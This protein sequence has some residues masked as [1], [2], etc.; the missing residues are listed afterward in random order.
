MP[1]RPPIPIVLTSPTGEEN[2]CISYGA[3]LK[4]FHTN[5]LSCNYK[6]IGKYINSS[7]HWHGWFMKRS[8][9]IVTQNRQENNDQSVY[10]F[11]EDGI[12]QGKSVRV[13]LGLVKNVTLVFHI[14]KIENVLK[15]YLRI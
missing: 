7:K 9:V 13:T 15:N 5:G 2:Y 6:I 12:F 4:F 14:S 10:V 11:V 8:H 3:A 1:A